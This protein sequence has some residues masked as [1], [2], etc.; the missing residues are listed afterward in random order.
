MERLGEVDMV[1]EAWRSTMELVWA[2][3]LRCGGCRKRLGDQQQM[4]WRL[5]WVDADGLKLAIPVISLP[6]T[7]VLM[8]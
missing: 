4:K 7:K 8:S 1:L 5:C 3:V 6:V 2:S